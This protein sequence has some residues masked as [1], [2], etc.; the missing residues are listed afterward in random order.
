MRLSSV[1]RL[2]RM[3]L[4]ARLVQE[5]FAILG[6]AI[7][8]ALLFA[9]QVASTSLNG[10]VQALTTGIVGD[11]R[12]QV[13]ARGADGL[14]EALLLQARAIPGVLVA[15]PVL[16]V[17]ANVIG[18]TGERSV[19]LVGT[20][21]RFARQGGRLVRGFG[22]PQLGSLNAFMLP[23]AIA[24]AVGAS[25]LA[26]VKVQVGANTR[27]ALLVPQ[28]LA[29]S[30]GALADSPIALA[31]LGFA[32]KLA[33]MR[34]RLT[35]IFVRS[36][37]GRDREVRA[38]LERLAP[39]RLNVRPATYNAA[40]FSR[41]ARPTNQSTA[42]FSAL[43]A[44]VGFLFAFNALLLTVPQRRNLIADLR[45][46]GYTRGM[47][48][49]VLLFDALVLGVIASSLGLL[50]G[51]LLSTALFNSSPGYLSAAFPVGAQRIVTWRSVALAAGGGMGAA[52]VGVLAPLRREIWARLGSVHR[53]TVHS[54][55]AGASW[56][57]GSGSICLA[58]TTVILLAAPQAAIVGVLTLTVALLLFLPALVH[59]A[60]LALDRA[61]RLVT[62]A[63]P[64]LAV[65]ELRSRSNRARSIA[66][67]ATGAIAVF[68]SVAIQGAHRDIERGL[69]AS[70]RGIDS[71][72]EIWVTPAGAANTFATTPFKDGDAA[73]LARLPG[74]GAIR[75]YRG[76][77]LDWGDR[78]LWVVAPPRASPT[79]VSPGQIVGGGST[80]ALAR[81]HE[82]GWVV[83]S[84]ALADEHHLHVGQDFTLPAPVPTRF[85]LAALSTNLGW[86]PGAVI[87]N[88]EDY[89][90]AWGSSDPSAYQIDVGAGASVA[91]VSVEV[92]RALAA[93][94]GLRVQTAAQREK[95]HYAQAD[96]GL[97][98]L[99]QIRT[100]VLIAAVLAMAAAMGAMIW[101]RRVRLAD[102]KVDGFDRAVLWRALLW[103]S[104]VLLGV[105]CSIGA[106][107]GLLGQLL[108]SRALAV[109]SGFPVMRSVGVP[110]ALGSFALITAIA[111]AIV[112]VPGYLAARVRPSVSFQD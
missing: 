109:V 99:T 74:V 34:G 55:V 82:S 21:P 76:S 6:I 52:T 56:L 25:T 65:V 94:S 98:R 8:V 15:I 30:P 100:L 12:F 45:L 89:A 53:A 22:A 54:P 95:L 72:A 2:Y 103:E 88:A 90:R 40:L 85:R 4:R 48:V 77:F 28:L 7:G 107:F 92:R 39:R 80:Q 24:Q 63:S 84:Q 44:L 111:V 50:F 70:A 96:Q 10:S 101:Q 66:I 87:L 78:R 38:G 57:L 18:P 42:L 106:L 112:A 29:K 32:Q 37:P 51:E 23:A 60:V 41:A 3:R 43:S 49:E 26:P 83:L 71:L 79:P 36:P 108:L 16:E 5:L 67:A 93:R 102:M 105:G 69:D 73:T 19:D 86:P 91:A 20:N 97:S 1:V 104:G 81:L 33:G 59:L 27:R 64:Y 9:S 62:G 47:I 13:A 75:L 46:D 11:M 110:G 17:Q 35:S 14:D 68:G 31:S 61:Q 58:A